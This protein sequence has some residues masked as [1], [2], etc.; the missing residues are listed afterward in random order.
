MAHDLIPNKAISSTAHNLV[1]KPILAIY[2]NTSGFTC[3]A[4]DVTRIFPPEICKA[5]DLLSHSQYDKACKI[6]IQK[7]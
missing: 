7:S 4:C 5:K 6:E 1:G 2:S 3:T